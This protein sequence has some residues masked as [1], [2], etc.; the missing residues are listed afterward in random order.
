MD[1]TAEGFLGLP[2]K[3][4]KMFMLHEQYVDLAAGNHVLEFR[5][6]K[7]SK[8]LIQIAIGH[9]S[10]VACGAIFPKTNHGDIDPQTMAQSV[11]DDLNKLRK[12]QLDY[13]AK[14]NL[15]VK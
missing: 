2:R 14:H 1:Q 10:C 12:S 7:N 4:H 15:R 11:V 3:G 8:H 13:A 6:E 5:D 9:D